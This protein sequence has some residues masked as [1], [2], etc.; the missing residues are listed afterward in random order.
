[1]F[2]VTPEMLP[3]YD[4]A[5]VASDDSHKIAAQIISE[6]TYM[7]IAT[8]SPDATPWCSPVFYGVTADL[9]FIF[10]SSI[11]SR[12]G[13]NIRQTGRAS[14]SIYWGEKSPE[15]TDGALFGGTA[16]ELADESETVQYGDVLYDQR[17]PD[18]DERRQHPVN[19][20]EW[21]ATGRRIYILV[22]DEV[23]KVDKDDPH[24]VSRVPLDLGKLAQV[25]IQHPAS[26]LL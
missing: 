6:G 8:S 2:Q 19:A 13:T 1:M 15:T 20:A 10:I 23:Y 7:S 4:L 24:G 18:S 11:N 14:W 21:E 12:H 9:T 26:K 17:F 22:P 16:R 5:M 3:W 25:G